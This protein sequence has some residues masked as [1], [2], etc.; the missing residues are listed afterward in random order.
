M[1]GFW[2]GGGEKRTVK[3]EQK[4]N[5]NCEVVDNKLMYLSRF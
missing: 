4:R 2:K 5:E 3:V 1:V